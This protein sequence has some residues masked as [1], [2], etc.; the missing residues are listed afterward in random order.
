MLYSNKFMSA[1]DCNPSV[2]FFTTTMRTS[3]LRLGGQQ[4]NP[5]SA[6]R[7]GNKLTTGL[8]GLPVHPN[9]LPA[10]LETYKA[11]LSSLSS[12]I[13]RGVVYRQ[14]AEAITQHRL[15]VVQKHAGADANQGGENA[16][17]AIEKELNLGII[18]EV[19][20]M[21]EDEQSLV[22]KMAQWKP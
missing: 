1:R 9:P 6:S 13:P 5:Y 21:A 20:K 10:L 18:E 4:L 14:S 2:S 16:I 15:Q 22:A 11:T 17:Q 3:L 7:R 19:V 12:Q 8:T